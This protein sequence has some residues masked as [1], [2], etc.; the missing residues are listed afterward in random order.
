MRT[1][2]VMVLVVFVGN[3]Q[4]ADTLCTEIFGN[5]IGTVPGGEIWMDG[6]LYHTGEGVLYTSDLGGNHLNNGCDGGVCT[7]GGASTP[8]NMPQNNSHTDVS[9]SQTVD[10]GRDYK[11]RTYSNFNGSDT[12]TVNGMGTARI[13]I[14]QNGMGINGNIN[15]GGDPS[16]LIMYINGNVTVN[17]SAVVNAILYVDGD[18]MIN[19]TIKGAVTASGKITLNGG[20]E[21]DYSRS[22]IES[23]DFDGAC[24]NT[25]DTG[26]ALHY[27]FS[28]CTL[29]QSV[30]TFTDVS[31]NGNDATAYNAPKCVDTGSGRKGVQFNTDITG[32]AYQLK[33]Q[34]AKSNA[35]F[36]FTYD[37]GYTVFSRL[38][39]NWSPDRIWALYFGVT[40]GNTCSNNG[41]HWLINTQYS[42]DCGN[43]GRGLAQFGV[44]CGTQNRFDLGSLA[45]Q[46]LALATVYYNDSNKLVTYINGVKVDEDIS[47]SDPTSGNAP[48]YIAQPWSSCSQDS[49]FSGVMDELRIYPRALSEGEILGL[50][51]SPV[52]AADINP[53]TFENRRIGTK[54]VGERFDLW[55]AGLN[56]GRDTLQ[57]FTKSTVKARVVPSTSCPA[58]DV[59]LT[60]WSSDLSLSGGNN[61]A[62]VSFQVDRAVRDARI[63]FE[64]MDDGVVMRECSF[65]NFAVRPATITVIAGTETLRAGEEYDEGLSLSGPDGYDQNLS[66]MTLEAVYVKRGSGGYGTDQPGFSIAEFAFA[67][68][69]PVT[70]RIRYPDVGRIEVGVTDSD[71]SAV[72]RDSGG[73]LV[74]SPDNMPDGDGLI[75]CDTSGVADSNLTF[76]PWDFNISFSGTPRLDDNTTAPLGFTYYADDRN[77][78]ALL[79]GLDLH[80]VARNKQGETTENYTDRDAGGYEQNITLAMDINVTFLSL[81]TRLLADNEDVDFIDGSAAITVPI[82]HFNF[83]K[84]SRTPRNP[85]AVV[86]NDVNLSVSVDDTDGVEGTVLR[87]GVN[88][89][90][91][92]FYGRIN[93]LGRDCDRGQPCDVSVYYEVYCK[94]CDRPALGMAGWP[95]SVNDVYWFVNQNHPAAQRVVES[96]PT[97][98]NYNLPANGVQTLQYTIADPGRVRVTMEHNGTQAPSYLYHHPY[99]DRNVSSFYL[100][101]IDAVNLQHPTDVVGN[102]GD[103]RRGA[104]RIGE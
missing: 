15:M 84:D 56:E 104:S 94:N 41:A 42:G 90:A 62:R 14:R 60:D 49:Y 35:N 54:L 20:G 100:N 53:P 17:G 28:D 38:R 103:T 69:T 82:R 25:A 39:F 26:P 67:G 37:E 81:P 31:G 27:T 36:S 16:G 98:N 77:M 1:V 48:V 73:C 5:A 78:S 87:Q 46:D 8:L 52:N 44:F 10:T 61:P 45:G 29:G 93:P 102:P 32:T 64:W 4:A 80:I 55:V 70:P 23:A 51:S 11:Y 72:D 65:D 63:Q 13:H 12:I 97:A 58:S 68:S 91:T 74:D 86:G 3:V 9:G 79:S 57:D 83:G 85:V 21:V 19:G 7:Q 40:G 43:L 88:G 75:G 101:V 18:V 59:A 66:N 30:G 50:F 95:E 89:R 24:R 34:Y 2:L 47:D 96:S 33:N 92:F 71:W 76:V 22:A 99:S 6:D